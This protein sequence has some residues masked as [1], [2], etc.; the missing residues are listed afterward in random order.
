MFKGFR[1]FR[2]LGVCGLGIDGMGFRRF[3]WLRMV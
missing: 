2:G 3:W 1:V